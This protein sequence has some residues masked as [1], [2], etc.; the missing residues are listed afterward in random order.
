MIP[1]T[2]PDLA[3]PAFKAN[4]FPFFSWLREEAP[5]YRAKLP[6]GRPAWLITRYDDA[7]RALR[8]NGA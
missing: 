8:K 7:V 3:S 2:Q 4:P 5:M 6:D 1:F